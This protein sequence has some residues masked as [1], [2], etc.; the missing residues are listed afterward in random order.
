MK[1]DD[2]IEVTIEDLS[3][4]GTGIG[5][6]EGMT[7]FIKDA[8]IGDRV[9]AKIMKMK[10]NYGFARLMEVLT[11][12]P[13]R[14]EPLC[15]VARQC[16]GCQIQ[17]MS[18]E[19]QLAFKTRKVES[20]LK[21]IGKFEEIPMESIIG[22]EDPFHYRNKAQFPFGKN[23]TGK[24]SPAFTPVGPTASSR[25]RAAIWEKKSTRRFWKKSSPG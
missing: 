13:D 16:G 9:R 11:P 18:Y 8:V 19:A 22:M 25:I 10:K 23:G 14:V 12:S 17:A 5:K 3:E 20:N 15:P 6:F 21:R 4:E 7:F 1:K 24:S 2:L